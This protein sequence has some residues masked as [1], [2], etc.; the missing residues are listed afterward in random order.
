MDMCKSLCYLY[1]PHTDELRGLMTRSGLVERQNLVDR[2]LQVNRGR[3]LKMYRVWVQCKYA[4][5]GGRQGGGGN[6]EGHHE[7]NG[8]RQEGCEANGE[9]LGCQGWEGGSQGSGKHIQGRGEGAGE[10]E[11]DI[12]YQG[13]KGSPGTGTSGCDQGPANE[14]CCSLDS[15]GKPADTHV[16]LCGTSQHK[17]ERQDCDLTNE[18]GSDFGRSLNS[19]ACGGPS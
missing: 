3:Q 6:P 12:G 14:E 16:D 4:K 17:V 7:A 5:P 2:R 1:P 15:G 18:D 8:G 10:L 11:R 13:G 19:G 9:S